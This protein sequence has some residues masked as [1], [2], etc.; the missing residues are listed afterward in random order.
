MTQI[1][2][3]SDANALH[4]AFGGRVM[5]WIDI[6]A[7]VAAERHCRQNV[8]TASMDD[9]H[10]VSAVK[11]GW[12]V[13][14]RA[15]VIATFH[16]SMEVGVTVTAEDPLTG[17]QHLTTS[18]LMTF[19]ALGPDGRKRRVPPLKLET[20]AEQRAAEEAVRRREERIAR[21]DAG[22]TWQSV[23]GLPRSLR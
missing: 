6:A 18:A 20:P 23:V 16:T 21:K 10:F 7:A 5:S 14:V 17:E 8:V 4:T 12:I 1:I 2:L 19:V 13:T 22:R 3:P 9:L 11:V 15:R